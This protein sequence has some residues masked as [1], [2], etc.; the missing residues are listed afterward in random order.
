MVTVGELFAGAGGL[1]LGASQAKHRGRSFSHAWATDIDQHACNT[2]YRNFPK[3]KVICRP[4]EEID[5]SM[6]PRPDGLAFGFPCNDFSIVGQR[7]GTEGMYGKLYLHAVRALLVLK[8]KFFVAEN[9]SGIRSSNEHVDL[10][11]ILRGFQHAGYSLRVRE[12]NFDEYEVPQSRRRLIIVGFLSSRGWDESFLWPQPVRRKITVKQALECPPIPVNA[13]N[14]EMTK[15]APHVVERLKHIKPG[16]NVFTATMPDKLRLQLN[17]NAE[18]SQLYRRLVPDK[19]AYTVTGSG[20]GG[21]HVYHWREN[22]ALT[23]RERARLQT[24]PD[25]FAF[26]GGKEAVRK[27]IGMAV[28]PRVAM[29]IFKEVL[30]TF[31]EH[32]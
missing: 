6:L 7:R 24:F 4:V 14:H 10:H 15:H 22:R 13:D 29:R 19:P 11:R 3:T 28:P 5:F 18:I 32:E 25:G 31:A 16:E 17:C 9:V 26:C 2:F 12:L 20:G 1:A 27:Q 23:N 8:P 21:T 30:R